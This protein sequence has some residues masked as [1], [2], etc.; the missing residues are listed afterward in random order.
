MCN[1]GLA[2][3][4]TFQ[5]SPYLLYIGFMIESPDSAGMP[6]GPEL[7]ILQKI[8]D[9]LAGE[10][11]NRNQSCFAGRTTHNALREYY[12]YLQ[13]TAKIGEIMT[14]VMKPF[15]DIYYRF[16]IQS[17]KAHYHYFNVLYPNELETEAIINRRH[18]AMKDK[19][20]FNPNQAKAFRFNFYFDKEKQ[21]K[22]F[23]EM[24][25][26]EGYDILVNDFNVT[27]KLN[28]YKIVLAKALLPRGETLAPHTLL[29][30]KKAAECGGRMDGWNW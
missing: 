1:L 8:E 15:K 4:K 12:F 5:K 17:D 18:L 3:S 16:R 28:P 22:C 27:D 19:K 25:R 11:E 26:K 10:F 29:L 30:G 2:A 9:S 13:D 7:R 21:R 14:R 6:Q 20:E 24:A 23:L